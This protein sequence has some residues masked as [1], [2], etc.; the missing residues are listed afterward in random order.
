MLNAVLVRSTEYFVVCLTWTAEA[1]AIPYT[2][3]FHFTPLF[4]S[5]SSSNTLYHPILVSLIE[6][7]LHHHQFQ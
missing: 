4:I 7:H 5:F 2:L 3:Q 6:G 1:L